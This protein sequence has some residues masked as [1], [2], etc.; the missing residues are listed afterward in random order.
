MNGAIVFQNGVYIFKIKKSTKTQEIEAVY[1][2]M[3]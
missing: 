1:T 3:F 2:E